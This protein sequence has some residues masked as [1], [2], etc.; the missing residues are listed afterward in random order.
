MASKGRP[1]ASTTPA[2]GAEPAAPQAEIVLRLKTTFDYFNEMLKASD[3]DNARRAGFVM[4]KVVKEAMYEM[5]EVPPEFV[6]LHMI[7]AVATLYW[8]AT[9]STIVNMPL[10]ENFTQFLQSAGRSVTPAGHPLELAD[11]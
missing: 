8:A 3:S 10:P 5:E 1:S 9:G 6:E 2:P 11:E 4:A 7:Q